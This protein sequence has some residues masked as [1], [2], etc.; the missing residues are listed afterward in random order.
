M[1]NYKKLVFTM[2]MAVIISLMLTNT[3]VFSSPDGIRASADLP[4]SFYTWYADYA[5]KPNN[6]STYVSYDG[7]GAYAA[8]MAWGHPTLS[9]AKTAALN[10]C[11]QSRMQIGVVDT[12]KVYS[13]NNHR[14]D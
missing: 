14:T 1:L 11:N 9:G 6:K 3:V 13:E 7:F 5:S 2:S 8:G 10:S 12:C 4:E